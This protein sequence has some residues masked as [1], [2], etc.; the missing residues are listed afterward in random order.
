[1]ETYSQIIFFLS[2]SGIFLVFGFAGIFLSI[3]SRGI[4]KRMRNYIWILGCIAGF[5]FFTAFRHLIFQIGYGDITDPTYEAYKN[6]NIYRFILSDMIRLFIWLGIGILMYLTFIKQN[7]LL[8][9]L[10]LLGAGVFFILIVFFVMASSVVS[11]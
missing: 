7:R 1:M 2:F 11:M 5:C 8:K 9:R 3:I 10:F 4:C 6:W